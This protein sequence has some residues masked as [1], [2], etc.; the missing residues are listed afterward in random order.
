LKKNY[1]WN[2][3]SI[4]FWSKTAI[5]LSLGL[6]KVYLSYR[7]SLLLS[8][9][10]IQH[11]KTWTFTYY[12]LLLW[13]IFALL[14]PDPDSEYR[15]GSGSTDPIEYGSN[16]DPDP[17][18]DPDP[19]PCKKEPKTWKTEFYLTTW[20]HLE[21]R[22]S[23]ALF[24][25]FFLQKQYQVKLLQILNFIKYLFQVVKSLKYSAV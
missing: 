21:R 12:C 20:E 19:Q 10:A 2:F 13:V 4:F 1:R 3:F 23:L 25:K 5:Y 24:F 11:F 16:T 17:V 6:H 14:D 7:R 8:K 9:E 15:S 18:P 22:L